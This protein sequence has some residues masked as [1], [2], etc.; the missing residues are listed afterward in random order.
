MTGRLGGAP[1]HNGDTPPATPGGQD[2]APQD[3]NAAQLRQDLVSWLKQRGVS[4]SKAEAFVARWRLHTVYEAA[5]LLRLQLAPLWLANADSVNE[6]MREI[7]GCGPRV[8]RGVLSDL[9]VISAVP[10]MPTVPVPA[11][12]CTGTI[13]TRA[14]LLCAAA[15]PSK[16]ST[17][18]IASI[19]MSMHPFKS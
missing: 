12:I 3:D 7:L 9:D 13:G 10:S 5:V 11:C 14:A 18:A 1:L 15:C 8:A 4:K 17:A 6:D 16:Q 2:E 19:H